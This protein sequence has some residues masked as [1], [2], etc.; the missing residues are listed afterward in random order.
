MTVFQCVLVFLIIFICAYVMLDRI[1]RCFEHCSTAKA[2][3]KLSYSKEDLS[4]LGIKG[5][6]IC[7]LSKNH[8]NQHC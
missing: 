8:T 1:C 5:I 4:K 6:D 2:L 7:E 3:V